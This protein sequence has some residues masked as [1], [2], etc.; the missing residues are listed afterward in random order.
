MI[1]EL[2]CF[3]LLSIV[4]II[5]LILVC[6]EYKFDPQRHLWSIPCGG[7]SESAWDTGHLPAAAVAASAAGA[8]KLVLSFKQDQQFEILAKIDRIIKLLPSCRN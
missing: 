1:Y 3:K 8:P 4:L 2:F 6:V 7:S 5:S